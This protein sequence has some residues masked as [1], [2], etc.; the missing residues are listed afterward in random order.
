[1]T[2]KHVNKKAAVPIRARSVDNKAES[3]MYIHDHVTPGASTDVP[4]LTYDPAHMHQFGPEMNAQY[5]PT[6][7]N[8]ILPSTTPTLQFPAPEETPEDE[9]AQAHLFYSYILAE[10]NAEGVQFD[11][12]VNP[13]L[14]DLTVDEGVQPSMFAPHVGKC[15]DH[16]FGSN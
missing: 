12:N 10:L 3:E 4:P 7:Y 11:E 6:T 2:K 8:I 5:F 13:F 15:I 9:Q 16:I 1:M 14:N